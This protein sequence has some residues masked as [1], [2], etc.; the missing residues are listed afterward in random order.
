MRGAQRP[1]SRPHRRLSYPQ[2]K[3]L[4]R[5]SL[6]AAFVPGPSLWTPAAPHM[7]EACADTATAPR[8]SEACSA[9]LAASERARL[10]WR[11]EQQLAAFESE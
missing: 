8:R 10:Q 3:A 2:I 4:A 1:G 11:L 9:F 6:T 7:I 5:A